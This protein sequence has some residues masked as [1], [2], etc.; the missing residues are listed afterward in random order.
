M[1]VLSDMSYL[2]LQTDQGTRVIPLKST[3]QV[4][5]EGYE[6]G[7]NEL[8]DNKNP[9]YVGQDLQLYLTNI[10]NPINYYIQNVQRYRKELYL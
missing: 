4:I 5:I 1:Q 8:L 2:F 7:K 9:F 10:I 3:I 6:V